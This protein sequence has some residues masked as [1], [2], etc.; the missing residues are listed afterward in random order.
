MMRGHL[1]SIAL[2]VLL[3]GCGGGQAIAPGV[4]VGDGN[5]PV[6]PGAV[7]FR[8]TNPD[9]A[10]WRDTI[11]Q[12]APDGSVRRGFSCA[13]AVCPEPVS[14]ILTTA[15]GP[16]TT[17]S[18]SALQKLARESIPKIN[19]STSLQLQVQTDNR[20]KIETLSSRVTR[21]R[22]YPAILTEAKATVGDRS[23]FST[24]AIVFTGTLLVTVTTEAPDRQ[25]ARDGTEAFASAFDVEVG[26][27]IA[28]S[29][30]ATP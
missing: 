27:L 13:V 17:P 18:D 6:P 4:T 9:P 24:K 2:A 11:T 29:A 23:I 22:A 15:R 25:S 21:V 16:L 14:V 30:P 3:A 26:P 5:Q 20:A 10:K 7:Q 19:E 28:G 1:P 12:G 8:L